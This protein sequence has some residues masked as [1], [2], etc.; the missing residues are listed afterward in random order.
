[1]SRTCDCFQE[2][3]LLHAQEVLV[4]NTACICIDGVTLWSVDDRGKSRESPIDM[5]TF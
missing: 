5:I 3:E 1:M 2:R 4:G